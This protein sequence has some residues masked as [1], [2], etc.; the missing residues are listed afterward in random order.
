DPLT[1]ILNRA[2]WVNQLAHIDEQA[3]ASDEDAAIVML[4]LDFLKVVNDSH[5][6]AAGDE[7]LRLTAQTISSVLRNGDSVGRLGGD[8][9]G[10]V[11]QHAT[12]IAAEKLLERLQQ[13]L[14]AVD[15]KISIGM[16]LKS[17]TG[18]LKNAMH[19]ADQRMYTEKRKKSLPVRTRATDNAPMMMASSNAA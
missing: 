17:E 10:V 3:S 15:I 16:A 5:G 13:A 8:E 7:L 2:G 9:F 19:Q 12:P 1:G 14:A 6:H 4:D 18:S 11:V